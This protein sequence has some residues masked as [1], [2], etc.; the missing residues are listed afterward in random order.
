MVQP[1]VIGPEFSGRVSV[2]GEVDID[3]AF[4]RAFTLVQ[5]DAIRIAVLK[6]VAT[7][8]GIVPAGFGQPDMHRHVARAGHIEADLAVIAG[9]HACDSNLEQVGAIVIGISS[10]VAPCHGAVGSGR[11]L[12]W[13]RACQNTLDIDALFNRVLGKFNID[14]AGLDGASDGQRLAPQSVAHAQQ[15]PGR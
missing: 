4:A 8:A 10:C 15:L 14:F 11:F 1:K 3:G 5:L 7:H 9:V 12:G 2:I 6:F 13:L